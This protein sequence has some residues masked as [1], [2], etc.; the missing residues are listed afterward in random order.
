MLEVTYMSYQVRVWMISFPI[1]KIPP[2][3]LAIMPLKSTTT[4]EELHQWHDDIESRL[5]H[6]GLRHISY[7]ADGASSERRLERNLKDLASTTGQTRT[8]TFTSPLPDTT[9][10][11]ITVPLLSNGQPR[12]LGTDGKHC[13][14]NG[15]GSIQSGAHTVVLGNYLAHHGQLVKIVRSSDSPLLEGD[16]TRVDKQDDRAAARLFSSGTLEHVSQNQPLET[17]LSVYLFVIGELIDAQQSRTMAHGTRMKLLWRARFFIDSWLKDVLDHPHYTMRTHFLSPELYEIINLFID[18]ILSLILIHRDYYP[19]VALLPWIHSTECCEHF[20][21]SARRI[22]KDFNLRDLIYMMP[23]LSLIINRDLQTG[24]PTQAQASSQRSGYYHS[25][26][27]NDGTQHTVLAT[28]PS[29]DEINSEILP[30]AY[31]EAEQLLEIL[32]ISTVTV[33][34]PTTLTSWDAPGTVDLGSLLPTL[35]EDQ[36]ALAFI[37]SSESL[38]DDD[39]IDGLLLSQS[40]ASSQD[41]RTENTITNLGVAACASSLHTGHVMY[42]SAI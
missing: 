33:S 17:G 34:P 28:Y 3:P 8:W 20:F 36:D 22:S 9:T 37:K 24:K 39:N 7:N 5:Q 2:F 26:Y 19:D 23:K 25:W 13:K 12:V 31:R 16:I 32:N 42:V 6:F 1:P 38:P 15:R 11:S 21:G 4:Q 41:N 40:L 27:D 35:V 30:N 29:D 10:I 18:S 14:K